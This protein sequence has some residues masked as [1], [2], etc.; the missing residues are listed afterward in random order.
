MCPHF[1]G[2]SGIQEARMTKRIT[3]K[4]SS[5]YDLKMSSYFNSLRHQAMS[6]RGFMRL[7]AGAAGIG[8]TAIPGAL[9][10]LPGLSVLAQDGNTF[11]FALEGDV[12]GLEPALAYDFTANPVVCNISEGLMKL[13]PDGT[14][15]PLLAESYDHPDPLTYTYKI[16]TGIMF[17]NGDEMTIDDVIASI[18]RVRDPEVGS[19][20]EWFYDP[21]AN[22]ERVDD[23]TVTVTLSEPSAIYQYVAA[24]TAGH[25]IP[26]SAIEEFGLDLLRNPV[27]TGPFRFVS[28]EDGNEIVLEKNADYWQEGKPYFDR[29]VFKIV[30][31]ATTRTAG[32]STGELNTQTQVSPDDIETIQAME[33]VAW[34]EIVGYTIHCATMRTDQPPFDD[35]NVRKAVAMAIPYDD[36]MTNIVKGTGI[37]ANSTTVPPDMPGSASADITAVPYDIEA[38]RALLA[39]SSQPDGFTFNYYVIAPNPVWIPLAVAVQEALAE[40]NITMEIQQLAYPDMITLQQAGDYDGMMDFQWA[41]DFPDANGNLYALLHTDNFPP[42]NNHAYYSNPEVDELLLNAN[43]ESDEAARIEMLKQAQMII[44]EE[45]PMLWYEHYKWFMP[46]SSSVTGYKVTPLWYWDSIG[47]DLQAAE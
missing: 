21:V 4:P 14:I 43:T 10:F 31:E 16:K 47:R 28:W 19:P 41:S 23:T 35:L 27:G 33:N 45:Q 37:R 26:A 11:T 1:R 22:V 15:E 30:P 8:A 6:R 46:M 39:E 5:A 13:L 36:I 38:A 44:A 20:M 34:Q 17:H 3:Q 18:E 7:G 42:N 32:M 9:P 24:T 2:R 40:L 25:V 29:F 12:R